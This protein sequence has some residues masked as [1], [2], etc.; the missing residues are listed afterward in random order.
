MNKI[1][2]VLRYKQT[3]C[4]ATSGVNVDNWIPSKLL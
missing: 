2:N 4:N 1:K 3:Y